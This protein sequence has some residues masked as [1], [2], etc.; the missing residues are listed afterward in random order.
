MAGV[1]SNAL[2][3]DMA[4]IIA[5]S[6]S[7]SEIENMFARLGAP[8]ERPGGN[9]TDTVQ[10]WLSQ[11][12]DAP[13]FDAVALLGGL[14]EQLMDR[15]F[16]QITPELAGL[17]ERVVRVLAKHGMSYQRGGIILGASLST[18]SRSLEQLIREGSLVELR[19]EFDRA[20]ANVEADPP[21][22][23]T[24]ACAI[25]ETLFKVIIADEGLALPS[26]MSVLPLWR[27]VQSHLGLEPGKAVDPHVRQV[28]QGLAST[29]QGV[30]GLRSN[31]GSAHGRGPGAPTVEPRHARLAVH[32]AHTVVGFV[33]ETRRP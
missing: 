33:L 19:R 2:I 11:A 29:I 14:L 27:I 31:L 9:K 26:D 30:A 5:S 23:I 17:R 13:D 12:N 16:R 32:A 6:H 3:A 18:P 24:A 22:A 8:G 1:L 21:A 28:L 15:E 7:R 25:L 4:D 20:L 10:S